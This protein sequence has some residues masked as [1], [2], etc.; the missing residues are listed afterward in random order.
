MNGH[1]LV[2]PPRGN[3]KR[4][5]TDEELV[6]YLKRHRSTGHC[7]VSWIENSQS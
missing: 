4:I 2:T 5:K 3:S 6:A 7:L 1:W